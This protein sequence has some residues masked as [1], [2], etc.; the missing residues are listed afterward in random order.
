MQPHEY[1]LEFMGA[2]DDDL[3]MADAVIRDPAA[4]DSGIGFHLQQ[5]AE[6][7]LKAVLAN[8][9]VHFQRSHD[10]KYLFEQVALSGTP[11]P[12]ELLELR[13][14]SPFA[15][16]LRYIPSRG[17]RSFDRQHMWQLVDELR[18]WALAEVSGS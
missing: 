17:I 7:L 10:L 4:P 12:S 3:Y 8:R 16:P 13:I 6:K 15:A 2:A 14:L 18:A 9:D 5:A 1:A 11:A